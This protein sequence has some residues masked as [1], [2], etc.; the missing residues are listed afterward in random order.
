MKVWQQNWS[1]WTLRNLLFLFI[2]TSAARSVGYYLQI[3][4]QKLN[5]LVSAND[6]AVIPSVNGG[7]TH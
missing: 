3:H 6:I 2:S 1:R 4:I 7:N 5:V